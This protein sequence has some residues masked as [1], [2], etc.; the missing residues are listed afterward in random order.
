MTC[1]CDITWII[2]WGGA[3]TFGILVALF[4]G[5]TAVTGDGIKPGT[6]HKGFG[7]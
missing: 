2:A 7:R 6:T 5:F 1:T 4:L 3:L